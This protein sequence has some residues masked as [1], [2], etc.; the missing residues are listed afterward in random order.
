MKQLFADIEADLSIHKDGWCTLE[1]ANTL[2]SLIASTRPKL[3]TEVGIWAGRSFLP[4]ALALKHVGSG[5]IVGIDPW[6]A[7]ESAKE[8]TGEDLK[9]WATVD[10]ERIFNDFNNWIAAR[11]VGPFVEIHRCRSDQFDVK[12][13]LETNGLIDLCHI[14]GSH[15]EAASVFDVNNFAANTRVGGYCY[16]DDVEWAKKASNMLPSMGFQ[17]LFTID[18]GAL[19]QRLN[20]EVK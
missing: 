3:I 2:A 6:K 5:K 9:W 12:R 11:G 18:G 7:E 16:F 4:M 20:Y 8:M 14:D 17:R 15:G 13:M 1:K 10:H 19:Y